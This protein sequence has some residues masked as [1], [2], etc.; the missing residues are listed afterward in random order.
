M[1]R[2]RHDMKRGDSASAE[3]FYLGVVGLQP[4]N[5]EAIEALRAIERARIRQEHLLKPGRALPGAVD[6]LAKRPPTAAPSSNALLMEQASTLARQGDHDEAI[7]MMNTQ[8]KAAPSD[9]AARDL[10]AELL[11]KKAQSLHTRDP[12][13]AQAALKRCLQV[14]PRHTG[15]ESASAAFAARP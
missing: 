15:C 7:E 13:A 2:A 5:A 4:H 10:L 3:Q 6:L 8:L 14:A 1:L 9:Q 11:Y 12:A